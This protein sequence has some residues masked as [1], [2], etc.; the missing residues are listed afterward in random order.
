[1]ISVKQFGVA[2]AALAASS[3]AGGVAFAQCGTASWYHEGTRTA[4]GERYNPEAMTAAHRTLPMG[5]RVVVRH[6]RTGRSI[7][8][9]I[10]DRGPFIRGRIIDLSRAAKREL[11]MGGLAPVCVT[12]MG[13]EGRGTAEAV[14][15][16]TVRHHRRAAV[17]R[18]GHRHVRAALRAHP[19][20]QQH[21]TAP[22]IRV[23]A[24]PAQAEPLRRSATAAL[25]RSPTARHDP[26]LRHH[27]AAL[28]RTASR[29]YGNPQRAAFQRRRNSAQRRMAA[30]LAV[31]RHGYRWR[32]QQVQDE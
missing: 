27:R 11:G 5:T 12:A 6:Q 23:A 24:A 7:V 4:S 31:Y 14:M 20:R 2:A 25:H 19:R 17:S 13:R 8:V 32:Q 21:A 9:R 28:H 15:P 26:A 18:G 29:R 1:M 30:R 10:N 16:R 22:R 3:L